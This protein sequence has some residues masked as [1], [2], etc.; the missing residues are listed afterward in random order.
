MQCGTTFI[1]GM[2][3]SISIRR[4]IVEKCLHPFGSLRTPGGSCVIISSPWLF[5]VSR[6]SDCRPVW[7]GLDW[8]PDPDRT[9]TRLYKCSNKKW[10]RRILIYI[11]IHIYIYIYIYIPLHPRMP[12]L[13]RTLHALPSTHGPIYVLLARYNPLVADLHPPPPQLVTIA[14]IPLRR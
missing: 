8:D 6:S 13:S 9:V 2:R 14:I 1:V 5:C 7:S 12:V 10:R 4:S 11:Y 3:T